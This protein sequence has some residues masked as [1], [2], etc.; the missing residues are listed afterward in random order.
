[1]AAGTTEP[2]EL[3]DTPAPMA[4]DTKKTRVV[5]VELPDPT[6]APPKSRMPARL[7]WLAI[8]LPMIVGIG[9]RVG[10]YWLQFPFWGD[11]V[12]VL[13]NLLDRDY[14]G[15]MQ[16]LDL[17]QVAP[18][19]FLWVHKTALIWFGA[20]EWSLRLPSL[21]AGIGATWLFV[22]VCRPFLPPVAA[23]IGAAIFAVSYFPVRHACE[24]KPYAFDLLMA[25][26]L[27]WAGLHA[28]QSAS[29]SRFA[30]L[31]ALT[32]FALAS[33]YPAVFVGGA[34]SLAWL[35]RSRDAD[36]ATRVRFAIFNVVLVASFL[37]HYLL[38]GRQQVNDGVARD[39]QQFM[40]DYWRDAFPPDSLLHWPGWLL[41]MHTSFLFAYPA[42]GPRGLSTLSF[43]VACVGGAV[44]WRRGQWMLLTLCLAPFALTLV[45]A[46]LHKYPYGY[47]ARV[48]QHL[49]PFVVLLMAVGVGW[50]VERFGA[51]ASRDRIVAWCCL[52]LSL[53]AV[54]GIVRDLRKPMKTERDRLMRDWA[55]A[56][57]EAT[58]PGDMLLTCSSPHSVDVCL[59]W[60]LRRDDVPFRWFNEAEGI[61]A[62][63]G[64]LWLLHFS[65][66]PA[67]PTLV[68]A[69]LGSHADAWR[70]AATES[71]QLPPDPLGSPTHL[72]KIRM[73]RMP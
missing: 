35:T 12:F 11:E 8:A 69:Q 31:L 16:K 28:I 10:R 25:V 14:A 33:S 6:N 41:D 56:V 73:I 32:P 2:T 46:C 22:R 45:A 48:S 61:P 68:V 53:V 19:M 36:L 66:G 7:L 3:A 65:Q 21:V 64:H 15:L 71:R 1:M 43:L 13:L 38:I 62:T 60:Y 17:G 29:R 40:Q 23:T 30:V 67:E 20:S 4:V 5:W 27:A 39:T 50:L 52:L 37:G 58:R 55:Q 34:V 47:S 24:V 42:G 49:A 57:C 72:L 59:Q 44:L 51:P 26:A 63:T 54:I 18:L 9:W 70:I